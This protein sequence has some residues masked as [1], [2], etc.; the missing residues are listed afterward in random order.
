MSPLTQ[1]LN[2]R[3]TCDV[4]RR[5]NTSVCTHVQSLSPPSPT[6]DHSASTVQHY[7]IA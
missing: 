4:C 2:Y 1:G 5:A 3:S 6:A 7:N